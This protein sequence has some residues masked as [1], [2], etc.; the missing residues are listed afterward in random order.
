MWS[1]PIGKSIFV[2]PE[3]P[4]VPRAG[5][6]C[7]RESGHHHSRVCLVGG[8][9]GG[10]VD[11][12]HSLIGGSRSDAGPKFDAEPKPDAVNAGSEPNAGPEPNVVNAG[13]EP[14]VW[15][16]P[17]A[18]NTGPKPNA[19]NAQPKPDAGLKPKWGRSPIQ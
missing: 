13:P 15:P 19:V 6:I 5:D 4:G 10:Q 3:T 9:S 1:G 18:V 14:D 16:K 8:D 2:L 7:F 17:D 12:I 11:E